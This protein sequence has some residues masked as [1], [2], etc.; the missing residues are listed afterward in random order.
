MSMDFSKVDWMHAAGWTG[1]TFLGVG[2]LAT[3]P[4]SGPIIAVG[5][6]LGIGVSAAT[7]GLAA[8]GISVI[9]QAKAHGDAAK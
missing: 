7:A 2:L 4:I 6:A 1:A 8:G 5:T 3:L 9:S